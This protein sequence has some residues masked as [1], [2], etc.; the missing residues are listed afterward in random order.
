MKNS[1]KILIPFVVIVF[2]IVFAFGLNVI[3]VP[4]APPDYSNDVIISLERTPCYGPCP[5][6]SVTVFE[7]GSVIYE[8]KQHVENIGI[9]QYGISTRDTKKIIDKFY[10][11]NYF[12]L[13]DRYEI[14]STDHPTVIT[15]FRN[16]SYEK[17][18]S[19]YGD[20]GPSRLHELEI[21]VD[22]LSGAKSMASKSIPVAKTKEA[23]IFNMKPNTMEYF[24][25]P[26]PEKTNDRD[27]FQ[28]FILIRLPEEIGGNVNNTSSFRAYSAVSLTDH[29][30]IKYWPQEQRQRMENPCRGDMYRP[31]DGL[32]ISGADI[33][34]NTP[35]ALPNLDLSSDADGSLIIETPK[36][37]MQENGVISIGRQISLQEIRQNSQILIDSFAKNNPSFPQIPLDFTGFTLAKV[38]D[39]TSRAE[40]TYFDF[41]SMSVLFID[42]DLLLPPSNYPNLANNSEFWQIGD[43]VIEI[44]GSAMDKNNDNPEMYKTYQIDFFKDAYKFRIEGKNLEFM[45]KEIVKNYFPEYSYDE[46]FLISKNI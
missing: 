39:K 26:N 45:K 1:Y 2:V 23:S 27:P 6:Y 32:L 35:I 13:N 18:V 28:K 4:L 43:N 16:E 7:N 9:Y 20:A 5:V 42:I 12:S 29:C 44:S 33:L 46:M 14:G 31:I 24:Y 8:G 36:W 19:N 11:I 15:S 41:S 34:T 10:E 17:I 21:M 25:Y 22:D 3:Y 38:I 40:M 37:T 30:L